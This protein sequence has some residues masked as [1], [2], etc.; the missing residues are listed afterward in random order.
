[1]QTNDRGYLD[2]H[3]RDPLVEEND[4]VRMSPEDV[5]VPS[6]SEAREILPEPFWEGQDAT[7]AC[8][9][10]V[11]ELAFGNLRQ[12]AA[13]SGF[14]ANFIDTAFND[15][16]FM[17]DSAFILL[18]AR[19]GRRAFDFQRT[20]DNLYASQHPD[21]FICREISTV[22]GMDRFERFDATS[23]GP[24]IMP[25]TEWEHYLTAGDRERLA[26]VFPVLVSYHRWLKRHRTW[27]DGTYWTSGLGSGMDNQPRFP[28]RQA[29]KAGWPERLTY[30]G[31]AVW[32]DMC[33]QQLLSADLLLRMADALGRHEEV[34]DL[35]EERDRLSLTVNERL[36]NEE[37]SFYHDELA[38]GELSDVQTVGAY[39]ALLADAVPSERVAP[40][41]GHLE[42]PERFKR[43]H[44]VPSLSAGHPEYREDGGYWLGG[45]W[46]PTNYMVLRGLDMA[47]YNELAH[48]ISHEDLDHVVRVFEET[49]TMWENYA[50]ERAAPGN[51]AK[52]DFVG[53][54]G[55]AP[56]AGLF[57]YVFGLRPDAPKGRLLWD[58]RLL[59][60]HGVSRYPFGRE[61]V[62]DLSCA[63]R[64]SAGEEPRIE[65]RST[66]PLE[67][68]VRWEEGEKTV[69]VAES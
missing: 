2:T 53:W 43:R 6:F 52:D 49:G 56:V 57:E 24:N 25:W 64:G 39:W 18:F 68:V 22:D 59:D 35:R 37:T 17:W 27:R 32:I 31:H 51:P 28:E 1:M 45:V 67:L 40:F 69:A 44:R 30:H 3:F 19:Y 48:E 33:L 36:W 41:V 29:G 20:L 9:W 66:V 14:V 4:F 55:L 58:V 13:G 16:L 38:E 12:P 21:G 50:P 65:A 63:P 47:C 54:S 23:T 10:R 8:Y 46:P 7:I 62:L 5:P 61:G 60:S 26:R 34:V 42:D 15:C 11:W